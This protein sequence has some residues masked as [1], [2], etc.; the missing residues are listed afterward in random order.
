MT[1]PKVERVDQI[2]IVLHWLIKMKVDTLIDSVW[3]CSNNNWKGLS[4]G[5]LSVLF[6]T[7]VIYSLN[8]RLSYMETWVLEHK[9]VLEKITNWTIGDKDATDDRLAILLEDIGRNEK[10]MEDFQIKSGRNL[11]QAYNLPTNIVRSDTT[12]V[13]TYHDPDKN[14]GELLKFGFSKDHRPDLLQFKLNLGTLDP[15]G[16]PIFSETVSGNVADDPLYVPTWRQMTKTIGH[17]QFLY[18]ADSKASSLETRA[19]IS[20]EKGNYLF[21]L[22]KTGDI[23]KHLK[24]LVLNPPKEQEIIYLHD[25][26]TIEKWKKKD[27][28]EPE[29]PVIGQGFAIEKTMEYEK[30]N[31]TY[32]WQERWLISRSDAHAERQKKSLEGR[33]EKAE[34]ALS[35]LKKKKKETEEV[36]QHRAD[37]ILKKYRVGCCIDIQITKEVT[38]KKRYLKK[39]RP[40]KNTPY[41]MIDIVTLKVHSKRNTKAIKEEKE[42]AGWRICVSNV[43]EER[44]SVSKSVQYY[45]DEWIVERGMHRF[46]RGCLPI[47]P[48]FLKID[49]RIKGLML[50]LTIA[51]Q[52]ITSIEFVARRELEKENESL[53]GLVPGNPARKI[54]RPTTERLFHQ[55]K[56]LN[57]LTYKKEGYLVEKLTAL[58]Q[59]ILSL[60]GLSPDIYDLST[61][62]TI[63]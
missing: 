10:K 57:Y 60:L 14:N 16:I 9:T 42:L 61:E 38:Q 46:K 55:F 3:S 7:Y 18:I 23:P 51:L 31:E 30:D 11:I 26:E 21:P 2:P 5:Q 25:T 37:N 12:S 41:E 48:L 45:R 35:K 36:F 59:R 15:A 4:Y 44:L 54:K 53:A 56:N 20:R 8:H 62:K 50:L 28:D 27:D 40:T 17:S 33:L 47:I 29:N 34:K 32:T 24:N 43:P 19:T 63:F 49:E 22:P 39:G 6:I 52:V 13:N 58:Q 1:E